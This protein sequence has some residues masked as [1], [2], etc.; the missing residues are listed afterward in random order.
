MPILADLRENYT[1]GSLDVTY[2]LPDPLA[3]FQR[4]F[5]QAAESQLPEPNA[6]HL[7][8]VGPDGRPSG[9]IV[10]LKGLDDGFLFFTNYQSRKGHELAHNDHAALTFFWVELE[11]QV[12][13]QGCVE[14]VSEAESDAYFASR[15][16]GSQI[17]AWVSAQSEVVP[18]RAFLEKRAEELEA[19]F[20][21]KQV[22]RPPHWG[23]YRLRPEYLEFWQGR[24][25]RLHDR[26]AYTKQQNG[27]WKIERLSP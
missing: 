1:R 8:T 14:R 6:M 11:R 21:G 25:S 2:V 20:A 18:D 19:Q 7:A 24:P 9:R 15:P 12:R 26:I 3:Q 27:I 4:W 5:D 16:R 22:P 17:G 23:G 10:L 13:V